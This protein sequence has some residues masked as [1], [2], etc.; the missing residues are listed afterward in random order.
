MPED[1]CV[2]IVV[3]ICQSD[4]GDVSIAMGYELYF[5]SRSI[6]QELKSNAKMEKW[7]GDDTYG[8]RY[9]I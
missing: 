9:K 6:F 4:V 5:P 2:S 7:D 1:M 3:L 8:S